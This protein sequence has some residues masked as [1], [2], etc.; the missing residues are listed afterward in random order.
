ML[1]NRE[2]L[3]RAARFSCTLGGT[4][5]HTV[6]QVQKLGPALTGVGGQHGRTVTGRV[7]RVRLE[8]GCRYKLRLRELRS[9]V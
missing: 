7:G 9:K 6:T 8:N 5:L 3:H 2:A 4:L 1:P